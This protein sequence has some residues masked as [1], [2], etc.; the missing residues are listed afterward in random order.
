MGAATGACPAASLGPAA[1]MTAVWVGSCV[2]MLLDRTLLVY[3]KSAACFWY[4]DSLSSRS[5]VPA[6][7]RAI[8]TKLTPLVSV[9]SSGTI[10][11]AVRNTPRQANGYDCGV[12][13]LAIAEWLCSNVAGAT[14]GVD[15]TTAAAADL[16]T[17]E[18]LAP[19]A[20]SAKRTAI[21]AIIRS[22]AS[23]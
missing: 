8:A 10:E 11:V 19:S 21:S 5:A 13:V 17:I 16:D 12:Y 6:H 7:A 3:C 14:A 15:K 4:F 9:G 1:Q 18:S 2:W 20:I 23:T 22:L